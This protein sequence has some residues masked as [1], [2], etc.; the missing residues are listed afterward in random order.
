MTRKEL[1]AQLETLAS[2]TLDTWPAVATVLTSLI[3]AMYGDE[4][5]RMVAHC[6]GVAKGHFKDV[7]LVRYGRIWMY[8]N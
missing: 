2:L 3:A 8:P 1:I 4:E 6:I 7:D 5:S